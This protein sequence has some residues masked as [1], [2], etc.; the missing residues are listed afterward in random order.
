MKALV[1]NIG[2]PS[3]GDNRELKFLVE[4][5]WKKEIKSGEL[6]SSANELFQRNISKQSGLDIAP[7]GE[8]SFYDR[9][10]DITV[11]LNLIPDRFKGLKSREELY[12]AMARGKDAMEMS[13]WFNTNYHY[14]IP[15]L[16]PSLKPSLNRDFSDT[17]MSMFGGHFDE[18]H[19]YALIGPFTFVKLSKNYT[20]F[21]KTFKDVSAAYLDFIS[22]LRSKGLKY[23]QLEEPYLVKGASTKEL[24]LLEDF[25]SKAGEGGLKVILQTYFESVPD[26]KSVL[27]LP[28][29][30]IGLDF[31]SSGRNLKELKKAGLPKGKALFAGVINGRNIWKSDLNAAESLIKELGSLVSGGELYLQPSCSLLHVPVSAKCETG[32][33]ELLR[34]QLAFADEKIAELLVLKGAKAAELEKS[35]K[36]VKSFASSKERIRKTVRDRLSALKEKDFKRAASFSSRKKAQQS[37]LNLPVLPTTTIGSF[38]QT[39]EVRKTRLAFRKGEISQ[40]KYREFIEGK[41]RELIKLQEDLDI[42]VL[43]HGEFERTDMVEFFGEKLSGFARTANGWVQSYGSRCVKPP[44]I[45]G[46]VE[47]QRPMTVAEI[48]YAQSLT[49]KPVKGMLTGPVTIL[50]WSFVRDDIPRKD[51][52]N[53]IALALRNETVDLESAGISIIQIDEPALKEGEPLAESAV[54]EYYRWAVA[55]FKLSSSGVKDETQIHTHMCYSEFNDIISHIADMDADVIS[56]ENA[57]SKGELLDVFK[58]FNYK[59]DIGPGVYD[60]HSPYVPK[61][62]EMEEKIKDNL[63]YLKKEQLWVNPDCGLKTRR[64][65]EVLPALKNMVEAAK[66]VRGR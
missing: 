32:L 50:N 29:F 21:D 62:E 12:F 10:L 25:L 44:L 2:Y 45:W 38:P 51:V 19:K 66:R 57:R 34:D 31:V 3:I 60:I 30:G 39:P 37:K 6:S 33:P 54:E 26:L 42:D 59:N 65:E 55:S 40:D 41:I 61:T 8:F 23:L 35:S 49:K 48:K 22:Q 4:K 1:S 52:A 17:L 16:D 9:M 46:D 11:L 15:E 14:L 7:V 58:K 56:V 63:K 28:S 24:K 27:S 5:F 47:R 53:Q 43:V 13:K 64:D 36:S 20:D 18:K